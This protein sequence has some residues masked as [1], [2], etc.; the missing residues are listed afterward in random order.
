ME[1]DEGSDGLRLNF[2]FCVRHDELLG[3]LLGTFH[4]SLPMSHAHVEPCVHQYATVTVCTKK[5]MRLRMYDQM[6]SV[7]ST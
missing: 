1:M 7:L 6:F 3:G 2:V 4:L 5:A